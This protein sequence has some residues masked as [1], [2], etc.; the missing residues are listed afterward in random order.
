MFALAGG[1]D[2]MVV[3]T[4]PDSHLRLTA[5]G[6]DHGLHVVVDKPFVVD[7]A[8]ASALTA[9]AAAAGVVLTVYQKQ[10]WDADFLA[11]QKMVSGG[12]FGEVHTFE[13]RLDR[14]SPQCSRPAQAADGVAAADGLFFDLGT[15]VVD[16]AKELFGPIKE[17]SP[18]PA[19][20]SLA[21]GAQ[22]GEAG[23]VCLQHASGVRSRLHMH[24]TGPRFRVLGSGPSYTK[25]GLE[26]QAPV[27]AA[28]I[29][30][31][32]PEGGTDTDLSWRRMGRDGDVRPIAD[33]QDPNPNFY[34]MLADTL[35]HGAAVPADPAEPL[36]VLRIMENLHGAS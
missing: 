2:L 20:H 24:R 30:P 36:E 22:T 6:I 26:G 19:R 12:S 28:G 9:Q 14:W 10:Q 16:Q 18:D 4:P 5:A 29:L 17:I 1:L 33:G 31:L 35:L 23:Y 27:P 13:S 25:W 3:A 34:A 7:P 21:A 15:R 8:E 11:L 32:G